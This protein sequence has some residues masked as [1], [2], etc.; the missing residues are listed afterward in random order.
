MTRAYTLMETLLALVVVAFIGVGAA[1]VLQTAAYGTS[2]RR[3]ARRVAVRGEVVRARIDAA[4]RGA[5]AVLA[6]GSGYIVLWTCDTNPDGHVNLSELELIE[7]ASG[8]TTLTAYVGESAAGDP[9]YPTSSNFYAVAQAA[10][11]SGHFPATTWAT[12]I[13]N[14]TF[15]PDNP[16]PI[17]AKF[18]TWSLTL[19][20]QQLRVPVVSGVTLAVWSQPR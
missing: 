13:S 17:L 12:N 15:T 8:S 11:S 18:V 10:K 20:D 19:T 9:V 14:L 6:S 2:A 1:A 3:E 5:R 4:I 7:V 16:S